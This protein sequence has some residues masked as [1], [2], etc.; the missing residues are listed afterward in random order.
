MNCSSRIFRRYTAKKSFRYIE[1]TTDTQYR[2]KLND[3]YDQIV[4]INYTGGFD[5]G[6]VLEGDTITFWGLYA[7]TITYQ[8]TMGGDITIPALLSSYY[9]F[10]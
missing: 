4:L 9:V 7:G 8:S 5:Q 6:K 3:N 2:I 1:G 10:N